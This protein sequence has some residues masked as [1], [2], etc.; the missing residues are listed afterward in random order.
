MGLNVATIKQAL[1][2]LLLLPSCRNVNC[3]SSYKYL[4]LSNILIRQLQCVSK[5]DDYTSL[6]N[7]S[8]FLFFDK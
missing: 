6:Y 2:Q 7:L 4:V 1:V 8:N 5:V 3:F